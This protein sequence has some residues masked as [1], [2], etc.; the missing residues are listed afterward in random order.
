MFRRVLLAAGAA[1]HRSPAAILT[2]ILAMNAYATP[3][4]LGGPKFQ[5]MGPLVY[6][7]F[8]V[9]QLAVRCRGRL[10]ADGRHADADGDGQYPGT[11]K[12]QA[13]TTERDFA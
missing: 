8:A 1:G 4:L 7:Q 10:R 9:E 6:G 12:I 3:V 13:M 5:M 2:F 11:A